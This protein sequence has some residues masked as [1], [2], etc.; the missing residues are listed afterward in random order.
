MIRDEQI[1]LQSEVDRRPRERAGR[2]LAVTELRGR[3][4]SCPK[5][6]DTVQPRKTEGR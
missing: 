5:P 6:T 3:G 1:L 2:Q 4:I